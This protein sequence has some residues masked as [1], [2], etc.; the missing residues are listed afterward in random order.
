MRKVVKE[1]NIYQ[2]NELSEDVKEKVKRNVMEEE[3]EYYFDVQLEED[4]YTETSECIIND[5]FIGAKINNIYYDFSYSQGSGAICEFTIR[6]EDLNNKYNIL[7]KEELRFITDKGMI[8]EIKVRH[9]NSNYYHEYTF[10]VYYDYYFGYYDYEDVKEEYNINENDFNTIEDRIVD[11]FN[12]YNK[13]NTKS[14]FIQDIINLN[15]DVAKYGYECI[16]YNS[17]EER[18]EEICNNYEYLENGSFYEEYK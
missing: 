5:Y 7:N 10:K 18:I 16:E 3:Q 17:S 13:H 15:K 6:I 2:F 1:I 12:T 14:P 9:D 11:L 8:S 4:I